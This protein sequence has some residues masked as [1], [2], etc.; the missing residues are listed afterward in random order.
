MLEISE[1]HSF[2]ENKMDSF[3]SSGTY[4]FRNGAY[5]KKYFRMLID[6]D[7]NING[8][9]YVSTVYQLLKEDG[10]NVHIYDLEHFMQWGTP[11]DMEEYTYWSDY[12]RTKYRAGELK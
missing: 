6:R 10:L 9:Y 5:I 1:K 2:T 7:I 4:H 12:F 3:H 8:E 11:E